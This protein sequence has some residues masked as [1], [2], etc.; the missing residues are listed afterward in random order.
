MT[1]PITFQELLRQVG[2]LLERWYPSALARREICAHLAAS[3]QV[4]PERDADRVSSALRSLQGT[5][6]ISCR[7]VGD[8]GPQWARRFGG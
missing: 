8:G 6:L 5:G 4:D 3:H 1:D 7:R 2:E